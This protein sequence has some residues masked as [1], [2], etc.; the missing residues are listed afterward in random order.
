M[1][2]HFGRRSIGDPGDGHLLRCVSVDPMCSQL[3]FMADFCCIVWL[4]GF[5]EM[6]P[7]K[8]RS[9]T[10]ELLEAVVTVRLVVLL[11]ERALVE[12]LEAE[13]ADEVLGMVLAEHGSDAAARD[14]LVT[15]SAQRTTFG[16]IVSLTVR[17]ALVVVE[18]AALER[19]ETVTAHEAL[20]MPLHAQR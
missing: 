15:A 13:R 6:L 11:F 2:R 7:F 5:I 19:L 4:I 1:D 16:M 14:G 17:L 12:L 9:L 8:F 20:G 18:R 10:V 3:L